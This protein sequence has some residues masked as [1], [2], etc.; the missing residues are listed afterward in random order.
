M[1][2][3]RPGFEGG[4]TPLLRRM[5]KMKGFKNPNKVHY[6]ALNVSRIDSIYKDGETV[7]VKSLIEKGVLKKATA[8]KVLGNGEISKKVK[9][10]ADLA[11]KSAIAKIEK[12]GGSVEVLNKKEESKE[13]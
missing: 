3:V 11:S 6:F 9:V 12:A 1:P 5:P 13:S 10:S 2:G 4:Q 7:D 8:I